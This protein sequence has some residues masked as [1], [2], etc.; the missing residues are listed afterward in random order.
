[1]SHSLNAIESLL[2]VYRTETNETRARATMVMI[3][4]RLIDRV[5]NHDHPSLQYVENAETVSGIDETGR[6]VNYAVTPERPA[7]TLDEAL[8]H[9]KVG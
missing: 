7:K 2:E 9:F 6:P 5:E 3:I 4:Q 1:M 8:A